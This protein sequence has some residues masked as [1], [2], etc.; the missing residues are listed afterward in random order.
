MLGA[1]MSRFISSILVALLAGSPAFAHVTI[2]PR[3]A[4]LGGPVKLTFGVGHGCG[5]SP[6]TK[7]RL[8][9]PEGIIAVK[10]MPKPGWQ[11]E[12]VQGAYQKT[13][14]FFHGAKLSQ[15]VKEVAWTGNLPDAH[16]DEFV[17][18]GFIA[19]DAF[20]AG[21]TIYFPV[22]QECE[23]GVHRWIEIPKPGSHE[24]LSEP[25]PGIRVLPAR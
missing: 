22:V 16:Y 5:T 20:A 13:Y 7:V 21:T 24:H 6:T 17:I 4:A 14:D 9:I 3:E 18:N 12:L 19:R 10:P 8:R 1:N 15:G 25:A 23:N 11:I 2:G